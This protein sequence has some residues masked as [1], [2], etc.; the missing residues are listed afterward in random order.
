MV[1][2]GS[3]KVCDTLDPTGAER[4]VRVLVVD[5][6]P[7]IV[8]MLNIAL[9]YENF[10]VSVARTGNEAIMQA[11]NVRPDII[12]LDIMLPGIDGLEVCRR[13]R[14][15]G[16]VGIIMLTAR[17]D[18]HDQVNGLDSGADDYLTKPFT[19]PVLLARIRAVLRRR[20]INL[21]STLR[22]GDVSLDRMTRRVTRA[23]RSI[24]LTPREFDLLEMLIAHPRQ[25]FSREAITNRVWGYDYLGDTNVVDVYISYLRDKLGDS[26]RTL[27]RSVRGVGYSM[28]P[29]D[30]SA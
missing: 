20:G 16:D 24:E 18:V 9:T 14:D 5:D 7:L 15:A 12:I 28:E 26:T 3:L 25:V 30:A 22:V 27:L 4:P 17:G 6:E 13:L 11:A 8:Q 21:Q 29:P 23:E 1:A 19:L 10:E 2:A